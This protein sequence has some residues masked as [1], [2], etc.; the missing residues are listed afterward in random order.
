MRRLLADTFNTMVKPL[1]V[2]LMPRRIVHDTVEHFVSKARELG[3][4]TVLDIG[5]NTGQ[6]ATECRTLGYRRH[7]L[8]FEPLTLA[9]AQLTKSAAADPLWQVAP[10]G[11]IGESTSRSQI[12]VAANLASSSLLDVEAAST[13]A[14]PASGFVAVEEIDVRPLD[15]L[16]DSSWTPPFAM[17]IDTQGFE[18]KVL[19]GAAAT[20]KDTVLLSVE[21]S[22]APL[23]RGGPSLPILF[24]RLESAGFRCIGLTPG[25]SDHSRHEMLQVDG[26]F[27]ARQ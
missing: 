27:V 24:A 6:F 2:R 23:Y 14:E 9:H 25:F 16:R 3:V 7:I 26:L 18:D 13:D 1:G 4:E 17:K 8:S 11:A 5:A 21:M 10:R 12:N 20:L 19:N 15:A 22:V